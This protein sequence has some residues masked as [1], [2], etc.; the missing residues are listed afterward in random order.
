MFVSSEL[1]H[2]VRFLVVLSGLKFQTL[3]SV[4]IIRVR[5]QYF[6][7]LLKRMNQLEIGLE[8]TAL[9]CQSARVLWKRWMEP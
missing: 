7:H 6:N 8:E 5:R 3:E 2:E 1:K 9:G 4:S